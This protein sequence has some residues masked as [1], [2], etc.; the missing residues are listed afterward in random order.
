MYVEYNGQTYA[1]KFMHNTEEQYVHQQVE[2]ALQLLIIPRQT[3][4]VVE[5]KTEKGFEPFLIQTQEEDAVVDKPVVGLAR[6][7]PK[8]KN[9]IKETGRQVALGNALKMFIPKEDRIKFWEVYANWKTPTPR[10]LLST[11]KEAV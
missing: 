6:V 9:Y 1:F 8:D 2:G 3:L 11:V 4:C 5:V 7:H 10:M